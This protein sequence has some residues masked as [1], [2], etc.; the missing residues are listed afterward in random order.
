MLS[1]KIDLRKNVVAVV[2]A[3]ENAINGNSYRPGDIIKSDEWE[4]CGNNKY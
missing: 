4:V 2:P 1:L 3:C